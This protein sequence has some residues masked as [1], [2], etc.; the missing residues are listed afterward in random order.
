[1][2]DE[3][4]DEKCYS[5]QYHFSSAAFYV[6]PLVETLFSET[7]FHLENEGCIIEM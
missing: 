6:L 4:A 5:E 2:E 3:A 7:I 1:M